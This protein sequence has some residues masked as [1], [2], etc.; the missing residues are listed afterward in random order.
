MQSIDFEGEVSKII[1]RDS[2]YDREAY[3]F[4]RDGLDFCHK[5]FFKGA[6]KKEGQGSHVT[7][8]Q[9]LDG[10]R[11]YALQEYGPM[12]LTVLDSWG[13]RNCEDFGNIVFNMVESKL[14]STTENDTPEEFRKGYAFKEAFRDPFL[15]ARQKA[16][17]PATEPSAK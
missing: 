8:Q 13:I 6:R 15:P 7:V 4:L 17:K 10:I 2:R 3:V 14:L 11:L 9:L 1:E 16:G 5:A 12:A